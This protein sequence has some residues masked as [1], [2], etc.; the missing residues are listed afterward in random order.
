MAVTHI[1]VLLLLIVNVVRMFVSLVRWKRVRARMTEQWRTLVVLTMQQLRIPSRLNLEEASAS[2]YPSFSLFSCS[3][4]FSDYVRSSHV[5]SKHLPLFVLPFFLRYQELKLILVCDC[6]QHC[7]VAFSSIVMR[8]L[9][10]CKNVAE[11]F[12]SFWHCGVELIN[13]MCCC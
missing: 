11:K 5:A 7:L 8:S 2:S 12:S 1:V 9:L 10:V 13:S 3:P 6:V 4:W